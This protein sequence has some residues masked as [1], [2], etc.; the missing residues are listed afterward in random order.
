MSTSI[1]SSCR[2]KL[3]GELKWDIMEQTSHLPFAFGEADYCPLASTVHSISS[4]DDG[5]MMNN[6]QGINYSSEGPGGNSC[7]NSGA[8]PLWQELCVIFILPE[9]QGL[10]SGVRWT[11]LPVHLHLPLQLGS[12][13]RCE[14]G[15]GESHSSV[16]F[17]LQSSSLRHPLFSLI[18][19]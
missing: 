1:K 11:Q 6:T 7:K 4:G 14:T 9:A 15:S 18:T 17:L 16:W 12:A 3:P 19:L 8:G 13:G 10:S 2:C 5:W